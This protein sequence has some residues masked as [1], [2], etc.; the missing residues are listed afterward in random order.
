ML[1]TERWASWRCRW[2]LGDLLG[3][4]LMR[5]LF[6]G[7]CSMRIIRVWVGPWF[8]FWS[9]KSNGINE[10]VFMLLIVDILRWDI[11]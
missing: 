9:I 3:L 4:Q 7:I 11:M 2:V 1:K 5:D 6:V 10:G 8:C